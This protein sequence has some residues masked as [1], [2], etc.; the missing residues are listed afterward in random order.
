MNDQ[1]GLESVLLAGPRRIN[2]EAARTSLNGFGARF[3]MDFDAQLSRPLHELI[4]QVRV[5]ARQRAQAAVQD[6]HLRSGARRNVRTQV[7]L[8]SERN[9]M[10]GWIDFYADGA[11]LPEDRKDDQHIVMCLPLSTLEAVM[12]LLEKSEEVYLKW[13]EERQNAVLTS[14]SCDIGK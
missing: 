9:T 11:T 7:Q 13:Q 5:E 8:F 14:G 12:R 3:Q 2:K 10:A 4:N 1:L 6:L